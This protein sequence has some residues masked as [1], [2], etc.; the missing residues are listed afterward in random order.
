MTFQAVA[1]LSNRESL[2]ICEITDHEAEIARQDNP[3]FD[4]FGLYLV[5]MDNQDPKAPGRVLAKFAS[6]DAAKS[7]ATFFRVHGALETA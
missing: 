5:A 3:A 6:E 4:Q 2:C 7:L 1:T